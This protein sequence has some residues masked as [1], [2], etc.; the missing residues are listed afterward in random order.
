VGR[1]RTAAH[2]AW[3]LVALTLAILILALVYLI[4]GLGTPLPA[5]AFGFRGWGLI[6]GSAF[7]VSGVLI[8]SRVPSNRIGWV[9][10]VAG[11]GT[12]VQEFAQEYSQYGLYHAPGAVPRADIAA[13]ITEWIWIPHM[14]AVAILIPMLYPN[15]PAPV[16]EET[17]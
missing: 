12:A 11:V 15:G 9:L 5:S 10:L 7:A 17:R 1:S 14:A 2:I 8:A 4:L 16:S 3:S 6:L 13:W